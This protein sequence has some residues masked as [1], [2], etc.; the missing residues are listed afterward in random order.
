MNGKQ[1]IYN[2]KIYKSHTDICKELGINIVTFRTRLRNGYPVEECVRLGT[3]RKRNV[4]PNARDSSKAVGYLHA[5]KHEGV[6]YPSIAAFAR[7]KGI[8]YHT[9]Y[10]MLIV[11]Y[12][13]LKHLGFA[14]H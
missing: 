1:I 3:E 12:P 10:S 13:M 6:E 2:G 11:N 8:A 9:A 14:I 5:V 7:Q 4:N